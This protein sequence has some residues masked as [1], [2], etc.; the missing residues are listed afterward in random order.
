MLYYIFKR[1]LI[2]IPLLFFISVLIFV[3]IQ[4][5]PGDFL[6]IY[7]FRLKQSGIELS[8]DVRQGLERQY[9]LDRPYWYQYYRWIS[10][11]ILRGDFGYSFGWNQPV[12]NILE[13]RVLITLIISFV[14]DF[15][16]SKD[17]DNLKFL[18][19]SS[20]IVHFALY[21]S[22]F[23]FWIIQNLNIN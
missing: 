17:F 19:T 8:P 7:I 21:P 2:L 22:K 9:G 13:E 11:I 1:V 4:L 20:S 23:T 16:S 14:V 10:N 6:D 15:I 3:V 18:S 5:P 12:N